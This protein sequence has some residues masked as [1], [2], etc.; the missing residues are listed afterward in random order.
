MKNILGTTEDLTLYN[1]EG[2]QIYEFATLS[3]GYSSESTYD[4]NRNVLTYKNSH[5]YSYEKTYN[6]NGNVLTFK[7]SNGYSSELTYDS[8]GNVL[9]YNDSDGVS[10]GFDIPEF[11]MEELVEKLGNFKIKK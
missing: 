11:T 7:N 4:V 3:D 10:R 9:T 5:G 1:K 6:E 2:K 8:N